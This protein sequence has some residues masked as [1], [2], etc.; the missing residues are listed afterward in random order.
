MLIL[1]ADGVRRAVTMSE[2]MEAVAS[3]FARLSNQQAD[4][5]LRPHVAVPPADG[6]L[7]VMP[8]Y[9]AG[10]GAGAP[11][12]LGVKLL[13]LYLHNP[14]RHHLPSINALVL[15][16]DT[17]NGQPLALMD[18]GW[19]TALR[20]GAASGVAT[21]LLARR[22]ARTLALFGAGAQALPQAWA[23]CVARPIERVWLVN[24]T[25]AHA[26]RLAGQLRAF[27]PPISADVRVATN[28][29]EALREADVICCATA[30]PTPIFDDADLRPGAHINGIGAYR[31]TMQEVPAATVA[32]ARVVVDQRQAAWAEAGDLIVPREQG[33]IDESHIA[34]ELGELV[35][36]R[37]SGRADD[38]Q[39]TFF[40]SVGNA[41]Q[42]VA[43][44]Q[45]AVQRAR[46]LGL[47]T[48]VSL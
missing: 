37:I 28:A 11:G 21:R 39:I 18:G 9:L 33:L 13:S 6:L 26:E 34:G 35:A 25:P 22:D 8:A 42:D 10:S 47:G 20:T 4:V 45:L 27:G 19:L 31:P 40:K 17:E 3:A 5:P 7:L 24:R 41:V 23:V 2:A 12:A 1:S 29:A 36:G 44:A 43:V 38:A 32:R 14:E 48:E 46:A 30:S 15:A 16:F